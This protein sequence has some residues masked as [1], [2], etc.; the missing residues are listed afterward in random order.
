[1]ISF[2]LV[3]TSTTFQQ[4]N[5][6]FVKITGQSDIIAE[7]IVNWDGFLLRSSKYYN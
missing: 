3:I 1:M 2:I 5:K 4:W 6:A 7:T